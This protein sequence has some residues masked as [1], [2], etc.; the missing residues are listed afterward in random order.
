VYGV[1]D[2]GWSPC[3]GIADSGSPGDEDDAYDR[4]VA[5]DPGG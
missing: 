5:Y 4:D 3:G 1:V 2:T